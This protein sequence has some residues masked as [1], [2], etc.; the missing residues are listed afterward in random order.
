MRDIALTVVIFSLLPFA[1]ARPWFGI[2]LWTWVG[3]M[4]PHKLT[5]GF[6]YNFTEVIEI[7]TIIL[8]VL[9]KVLKSLPM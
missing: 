7:V 2:L 4:N 8:I 6:A 9:F 5:F 1:F 3:L